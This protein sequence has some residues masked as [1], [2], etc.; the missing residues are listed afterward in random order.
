MN[1]LIRRSTTESLDPGAL[2]VPRKKRGFPTA[3][4]KTM[5]LSDNARVHS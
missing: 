5:W 4:E 1:W 2:C 3:I